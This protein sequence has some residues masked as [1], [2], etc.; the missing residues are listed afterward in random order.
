MIKFGYSEIK[1]VNLEEC[2]KCVID[3]LYSKID[4]SKYRYN[5]L[6]HI[7]KLDLNFYLI[8]IESFWNLNLQL[9]LHFDQFQQLHIR[10]QK[11]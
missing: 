3:F 6:N 5:I 11:F 9:L 2:K 8:V 10:F 4:L 1:L 7:D